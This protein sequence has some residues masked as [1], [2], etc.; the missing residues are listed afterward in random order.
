MAFKILTST[1]LP[2]DN[3]KSIVAQQKDLYN[4]TSCDVIEDVAFDKFRVDF[5][6]FC[7]IMTEL[8]NQA[9]K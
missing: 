3:L 1:D 4:G 9:S 8:R 6:Q 5:N 7:T 2:V